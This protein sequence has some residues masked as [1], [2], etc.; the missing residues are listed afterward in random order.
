M[1]IYWSERP[2]LVLLDLQ[3]YRTKLR[4]DD[5]GFQD[6]IFVVNYERLLRFLM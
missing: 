4:E 3:K 2:P 1:Y 6:F 5:T